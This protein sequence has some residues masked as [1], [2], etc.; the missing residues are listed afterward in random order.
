MKN[1]TEVN[2]KKSLKRIKTNTIKVMETFAGIGAQHKAITN[3]K[4]ETTY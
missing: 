4:E 1:I 2:N 3:I